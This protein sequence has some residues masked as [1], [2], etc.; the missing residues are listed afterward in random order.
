VNCALWTAFVIARSA[1]RDAA[2]S[3]KQRN[4]PRKNPPTAILHSAVSLN[5]GLCTMHCAPQK[6]PDRNL[7]FVIC[8]SNL[9]L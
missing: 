2:I 5:C 3:T 8:H 7:S 9:R 6:S 1:K 4:A